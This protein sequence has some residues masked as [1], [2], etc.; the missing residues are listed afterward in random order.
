MQ[1][2]EAAVARLKADADDLKSQLESDAEALGHEWEEVAA[3]TEE[4][5]IRPRRTDV[6]VDSVTLAWVPT[7][8]LDYE[9][10]HG[11]KRTAAIPAYTTEE[12]K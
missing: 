7:W 10:S 1:E 9:D 3:E 5:V 4:R 12:A 8:E 2:A 11:R 6:R